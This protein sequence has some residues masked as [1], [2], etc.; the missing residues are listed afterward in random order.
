MANFNDLPAEITDSII[1]QIS[2]NGNTLSVEVWDECAAQMMAADEQRPSTLA[3]LCLT[4]RKMQKFTEPYLYRC[5][6]INRPVDEGWSDARQRSLRQFLL[7]VISRPELAN[8]IKIV[9]ACNWRIEEP[10][11]YAN[12]IEGSDEHP[13]IK[14]A[15]E[16]DMLKYGD[17]AC[18]FKA[19][20]ADPL[21][22][23]L[24][25]L[26]PNLQ[27]V[28]FV[29]PEGS[30]WPRDILGRTISGPLLPNFHN[31]ANLREVFCAGP[32][33]KPFFNFDEV[34]P[35]FRLPSMQRVFT[36]GCRDPHGPKG[37][38]RDRKRI[39]YPLMKPGQSNITEIRLEFSEFLPR[40]VEG[41]VRS[42]RALE[43]FTVSYDL[44]YECAVH[45]V[46]HSHDDTTWSHALAVLDPPEL[47]KA[48]SAAKHSLRQL[49]AHVED[50]I[51]YRR[52]KAL[53]G[54]P[55]IKPIG[56]LQGFERLTELEIG[57][58]ILLGNEVAS[59]P[60][61]ADI[62]PASLEILRIRD[63][64]NIDSMPDFVTH[65]A[66]FAADARAHCLGLRSVDVSKIGACGC[67]PCW[68][69]QEVE[70]VRLETAFEGTGIELIGWW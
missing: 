18:C 10:S 53:L 35:F 15:E 50:F 66:A 45:G 20:S 25:L 65:L 60:R 6:G 2:G 32:R 56:S 14:A 64:S 51:C 3:N 24:L 38:N 42:C 68:S 58:V 13:F 23:L 44:S 55:Q 54:R 17:W 16:Y 62:L 33:D 39:Y 34:L 40:I 28:T 57:I 26:A 46:S 37:L 67:R 43:A 47:G 5:W 19:G 1:S 21:I 63:D 30:R 8:H 4:S 36:W 41:M 31:F 48:L 52:F 7:T 70:K 9:A 27:I 69:K 22:A 61:M 29:I 59:A 49:K 11:G 12:L